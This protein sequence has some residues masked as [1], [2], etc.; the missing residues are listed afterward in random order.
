MRLEAGRTAKSARAYGCARRPVWGT[1]T[2]SGWPAG[3]TVAF[4]GRRR[5]RLSGGAGTLGQDVEPP[6][7]RF[8]YASGPYAGGVRPLDVHGE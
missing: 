3:K 1:G 2:V 5:N 7:R 8:R 4:E 6:E